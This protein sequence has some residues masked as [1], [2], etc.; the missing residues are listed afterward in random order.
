MFSYIYVSVSFIDLLLLGHVSELCVFLFKGIFVSSFLFP[1]RHKE[2]VVTV[3]VLL[4][5]S[6]ISDCV[7]CVN[8]DI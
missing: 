4:Q 7:V 8:C 3:F 2:R 5:C 6:P 1:D